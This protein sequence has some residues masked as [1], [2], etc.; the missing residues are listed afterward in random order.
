ML[1]R[2]QDPHGFRAVLVVVGIAMI[3]AACGSTSSYGTKS[4]AAS[5]AS[6]AAVVARGGYGAP[7]ATSVSPVNTTAGSGST[8]GGA[9]VSIGHT[10]VGEI[11]VDA[12]GFTLYVFTK[13][14]VGASACTGAC[15]TAWPPELVSDT[16]TATGGVNVAK[17]AEITR[18]DGAKQLA[19]DGHPLYRYANDAKPGD[20]TGQ[21]VNG[22]WFV[23]DATGQLVGA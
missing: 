2:W 12:Q 9:T 13:D 3:A 11:L 23:I 8:G 16:P 1:D 10:S 6:S 22:V 7:V 19:Y 18:P 21:K 15:A 4:P 17:L 20:V 5:P 14:T